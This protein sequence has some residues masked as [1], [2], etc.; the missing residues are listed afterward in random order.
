MLKRGGG[1]LRVSGRESKVILDLKL[2]KAD[3]VQKGKMVQ[4]LTF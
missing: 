4:D 1:Q 2:R 3:T